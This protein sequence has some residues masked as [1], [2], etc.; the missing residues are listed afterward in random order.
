MALVIVVMVIAALSIFIQVNALAVLIQL[1]LMTH[2]VYNIVNIWGFHLS[3][4][5]CYSS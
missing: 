4:Q 3:V 5:K 1:R 2:Y